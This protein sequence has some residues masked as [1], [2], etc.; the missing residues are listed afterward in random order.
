MGCVNAHNI[1]LSVCRVEAIYAVVDEGPCPD[2][3]T[4]DYDKKNSIRRSEN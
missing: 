4:Y 2:V 1:A 3:I